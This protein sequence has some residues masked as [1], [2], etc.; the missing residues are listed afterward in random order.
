MNRRATYS[1]LA[2]LVAVNVLNFYDRHVIGALTEPIRKEFGLSDSQVGLIGS[3]FIWLY[4]IVGLPLGRAADS[5]S[6]KKLLAA[7]MLVWTALTG[8]AAMATNYTMLLFSRLGFAVGEAVVA[9]AATSWIGDIFPAGGRS[10]PLALFML[11]VPVGGALSYFFSGPVAQAY[12]W[13]AA[14]LLAAAPA[15]ILIPLLLRLTEPLRGAAETHHEPLARSSMGAI[16][17]I[18]TMWWIIASGALLNFNMYA[19]GTFLPAFL[20]RI[21]GLTLARSGIATGVVFAM[22][23]VAGGLLAGRL[24][25]RVIRKRENGRLLA[26]A[27]ISAIGAPIGYLG[28]GAGGVFVAI[29]LIALAYGTL[30]AYYGLVYSAIQDIVAP[31]M[32]GTAMAIYFLAMYLCGAS[33]GPLLTGKLSDWM[34]HR[35]ADAAGAA[36]ITEAFKAIGLQQAMFII[37]VLSLLLALVLYCG[38]RTIAADMRKRAAEPVPATYAG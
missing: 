28:I 12:G 22:G 23:G 14:M 26:A 31:A 2:V 5:W 27:A 15:V 9:P 18:P 3:A 19:I 6:R 36:R 35:A 34:A 7:G 16:L 29:A 37:P 4:A 38:S 13:R 30:N 25:D 17:K 10:R 21:H 32:R 1:S 20:S 11:G 8:V 24:G 33:F